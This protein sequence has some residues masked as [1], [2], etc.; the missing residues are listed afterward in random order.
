[1]HQPARTAIELTASAVAGFAA[2]LA[3]LIIV[4]PPKLFASPLFPLVRTAVE[5]PRMASFIGLA[6]VGACGG[7][8]G[9]S[10]W[11]LL[12]LVTMGIFP[13]CALAEIAKDSTSHNLLPFELIMYGVFSFAG[14]IGAGIGRLIHRAV[15]RP[16]APIAP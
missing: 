15:N 10:S 2:F 3:P 5:N 11:M 14:V 16:S 7:F 6:I 9:R 8:F 4:P 1:M 12:G 13:L